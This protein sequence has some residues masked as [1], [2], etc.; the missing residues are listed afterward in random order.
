MPAI[1]DFLKLAHL[2]QFQI[3]VRAPYLLYVLVTQILQ[4]AHLHLVYKNSNLYGNERNN[5]SGA[6]S[7]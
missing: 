5:V 2:H 6:N 1:I 3:Y 7:S 4:L